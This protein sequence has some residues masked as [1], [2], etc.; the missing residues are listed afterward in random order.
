MTTNYANVQLFVLRQ[1]ENFL[2]FLVELRRSFRA[3]RLALMLV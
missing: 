2:L 1:V 3:L